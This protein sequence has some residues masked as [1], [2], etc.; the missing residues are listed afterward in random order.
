MNVLFRNL[1]YLSFLVGVWGLVACPSLLYSQD[2]VFAEAFVDDDPGLGNGMSLSFTPEDS[3]SILDSLLLGNTLT[4]GIHHLF[5]RVVDSL[6]LQTTASRAFFI[7][8]YLGP[9]VYAESFIDVDPGLGNGTPI[10]ITVGDS[11][12]VLDSLSL[13]GLS[14]G[15]HRL[16]IRVQ[17]EA[18]F[19]RISSR[20]IDISSSG[21]KITFVE[22]FIDEDPGIGQGTSMPITPEDSVFVL[23]SLDLNGLSPGLHQLFVRAQ[24]ENGRTK[25]ERRLFQ[26]S[27]SGGKVTFLEYFIDEDPGI[28]QGTSMPITPSDSIFVLDSMDLNGL[29]PGLHQLFVR[30]QNENGRT[31][32]ERRLFQVSGSG[33]KVTFLEYFI[34]EDP[35]PGQ[36]TS[37]PISPADSLFVLDSVDISGLSSGIHQLFLRA[38]NENGGTRTERRLFDVKAN[39]NLL[40]AAEYFFDSIPSPGQGIPLSIT[41]SDSIF[42]T[43]TI[44]IAGL[45]LGQHW[46]GI[47]VQD[48]I[49]LWSMVSIDTF[50]VC[51]TYG[52]VAKFETVQTGAIVSMLDSSEYAEDYLWDFGDGTTDTVS[53]P[54]HLYQTAGVYPIKQIVINP[55]G[56]DSVMDTVQ[57]TGVSHYT[58]KKVGDAGLVS[59]IV[60]GVGFTSQTQVRLE[61][62]GFPTILPDTVVADSA[63]EGLYVSFDFIQPQLGL[64]DFVVETPGDTTV[65]F[66][67]GFELETATDYLQWAEVAANPFIRPGVWTPFFVSYGNSGNVD[68]RGM[69]M[70]LAVSKFAE[71]S[72][73]FEIAY[74]DDSTLTS[75]LPADSIPDYV[76]VDTVLG[77]P[78]AANV[79]AFVLPRTPP[80]YVGNLSLRL[81]YSGAQ[82]PKVSAWL[83]E[84][85]YVNPLNADNINCTMEAITLG[86]SLTATAAPNPY[87]FAANCAIGLG[88][89]ILRP[90][91][92]AAADPKAFKGSISTGTDVAVTAA[93]WIGGVLISAVGCIVPPANGATPPVK[94]AIKGIAK[95]LAPNYKLGKGLLDCAKAYENSDPKEVEPT[96][97]FSFDPNDKLGPLGSGTQHWINGSQQQYYIIRYEN[98]DTAFAAAQTVVIR[99]TLDPTVFDLR[100]FSFG[101]V[102]FGDTILGYYPGNL[103]VTGQLNH[104]KGV[105]VRFNG[106]IDTTSGAVFWSFTSLDTNTNEFTLDPLAGFLPPNQNPPEGE[107][108]VFFSVRLKDSLQSGELIGNTASIYFDVNEPI[109][110][111]TW[112]NAL[113]KDLPASSVNLLPSIHTDTTFWV[114]WSGTD[115]TSGPRLFDVYV[116]VNHP[117]DSTYE[118]WLN[119]IDTT[120]FEFPGKVDSSYFFYSVAIDSAG[121]RETKLPIVEASTQIIS[122]L[123]APTIAITYGDTAFCVGIDSITLQASAGYDSYAWNTGDTTQS[124]TVKNSGSYWVIGGNSTGLSSQSVP[125]KVN[126]FARPYPEIEALDNPAFCQGDS[127]LLTTENSYVSY[128][129]SNGDTTAQTYATEAIN[130]YL[131]SVIDSNGCENLAT[132]TLSATV[133]DLPPQPLLLA[134]GATEFCLGDSVEL[135]VDSAYCYYAWSTGDST[136]F[137]MAKANGFYSVTVIDSNGCVGPVSDSLEI[138]VNPLPPQP[139]I[140]SNGPLTFCEGDSVSLEGPTGFPAYIWSNGL[141]STSFTTDI[142]GLFSLRVVDSLGC[143]SLASEAVAV[144]VNP[145]PLRPVIEEIST[146]PLTIGT[147][148]LADSYQWFLDGNLIPGASEAEWTPLENGAYTVVVTIQGCVS[149]PSEEYLYSPTGLSAFEAAGFRLYPNPTTGQLILEGSWNDAQAGFVRITDATGQEILT[150]QLPQSR[151]VFSME[152]DLTEEAAGTYVLWI[153]GAEEDLSQRFIK[154]N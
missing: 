123:P 139:T 141:T 113:D 130:Y 37:I 75:I 154:K 124:I 47:R 129:W 77:E 87:T 122:V 11:I 152:F 39:D 23:D 134:N 33:G 145:I 91:A 92:I 3:V 138:F 120:A 149:D 97:A 94:E 14:P 65:I 90:V 30:A 35:G 1:S 12:F 72:L 99:D 4:N 78:F 6:G 50:E 26:I 29:A 98:V 108:W 100:S 13:S 22:Y 88:D 15:I 117:S 31:K 118:K 8:E 104:Y 16:F 131:I 103:Q 18:G 17:N 127:A 96:P 59:I 114:S 150:K 105:H 143:A 86:A 115:P 48:S 144:Q 19:S 52:P 27:G 69:I 44:S 84:P 2:I 53:A 45:P 46:I 67:D 28:G 102:G 126:V 63:G 62:P 82:S 5:V 38:H 68:I 64:Y 83:S 119:R 58:P 146:Q 109:V 151:Q 66:E 135:S 9:I 73:N 140:V 116:A 74:T 71:V 34:D 57:I 49:G 21:G 142:S 93:S 133:F 56:I 101:P 51:T 7:G 136:S 153:I 125:V 25:T 148:Q 111:P 137:L 132:D 36:G 89:A 41:S 80:E 95:A 76:E 32:T 55:C 121:N 61:R 60:Q 24:N 42:S 40:V 81:R 43:D 128:V 85:A 70:Y 20:L 106:A 112:T 10:P 110:T 54:I 107:G 147:S 79:Y